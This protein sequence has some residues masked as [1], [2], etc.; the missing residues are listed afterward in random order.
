[1]V[2]ED[3]L[4]REELVPLLSGP[5][6]APHAI[7]PPEAARLYDPGRGASSLRWLPALDRLNRRFAQLLAAR[8]KAVFWSGAGANI[9]A[10]RIALL[11]DAIGAAAPDSLYACLHARGSRG[12]G[13]LVLGDSLA[14]A[15]VERMLGGTVRVAA[16]RRL[17]TPVELRLQ[18]RLAHIVVAAYEA[19]WRPVHRMRFEL[20]ALHAGREMLEAF[21]PMQTVVVF[22]VEV[23]LGERRIGNLSLLLPGMMLAPLS[24]SVDEQPAVTEAGGAHWGSAV[25]TAAKRTRELEV[26]DVPS[27]HA[28]VNALGEVNGVAVRSGRG[29]AVDT[30]SEIEADRVRGA[31]VIQASR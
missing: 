22:G 6:Q 1:M 12:A 10:S 4:C 26:C 21:D 8:F 19:A 17:R 11:Q 13:L 9:A 24:G 27:P 30:R 16:P 2:F 29:R 3:A 28:P 15:A 18:R 7:A 23:S 31:P 20:S 5:G 25:A 14:A